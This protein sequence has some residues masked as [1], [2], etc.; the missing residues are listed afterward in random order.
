MKRSNDDSRNLTASEHRDRRKA[1]A[2]IRKADRLKRSTTEQL[3]K[4]DKGGH[5]AVK[6]RLRLKKGG[7]A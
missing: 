4:L 1:E 3:Q 5:R 2:L 6:E 7:D